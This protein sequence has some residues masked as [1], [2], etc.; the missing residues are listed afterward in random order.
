MEHVPGWWHRAEIGRSADVSE[1]LTAP[2]RW[3]DYP[4]SRDLVNCITSIGRGHWVVTSPWRWSSKVV[5]NVG[6]TAYIYTA[7][8]LRNRNHI[9]VQI[10]IA[11]WKSCLKSSQH[12]G[13]SFSVFAFLRSLKHIGIG[14]GGTQE[15]HTIISLEILWDRSVL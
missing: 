9:A 10:W 12:S 14:G 5:W 6:N 15:M 13:S 4:A 2:S 11:G 7:P 3:S 8:S 1:I